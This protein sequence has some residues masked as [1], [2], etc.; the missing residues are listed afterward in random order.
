[1]SKN[2]KEYW[3]TQKLYVKSFQYD[4]KNKVDHVCS[5]LKG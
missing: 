2:W 5:Q 4:F 3:L 1:M